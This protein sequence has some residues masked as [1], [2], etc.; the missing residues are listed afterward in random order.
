MNKAVFFVFHLVPFGP[1][2]LWFGGEQKHNS[3]FTHS[4]SFSREGIYEQLLS[5]SHVYSEYILF[6]L[7]IIVGVIASQ[8][9]LLLL[10]PQVMPQ[11]VSNNIPWKGMLSQ[12][13]T[14]GRL[15]IFQWS[16]YDRKILVISLSWFTSW[17]FQQQ[18]TKYT[19]WLSFQKFKQFHST[20]QRRSCH[21]REGR[22]VIVKEQPDSCFQ[23]RA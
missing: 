7:R 11:W 10:F 23:N 14:S 3:L 1:Q 18:Y 9:A 4:F 2:V 21:S 12:W 17:I 15:L 20:P 5:V 6:F 13:K 16:C 8:H 22:S 19:D